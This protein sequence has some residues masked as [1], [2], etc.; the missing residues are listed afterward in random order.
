MISRVTQQTTLLTAQRNLQANA[1]QLAKLQD[2]AST[3]K[4]FSRASEDPS[5]AADALRI[6]AQQRANDQHSRNVNN[7]L[8]WVTT[9]D[10]TLTEVND[11]MKR[12]RD[13]TVQ[14]ANDGSLSATA[15]EAIAVEL[16]SLKD[17]LLGL[18]NT[19]YLGRTVFAGNSSD[20]VAFNPD[21]SFTG[22]P[23]SEVNRRVGPDTT[24]R[25]DGDGSAVFGEGAT[26]VFALIEGIAADLRGGTN[27]GARLGDIDQRMSAVRTEHSAVGSRHA[28]IMR[29]EEAVMDKTVSFEAQ[30]AAVEDI[31]L[32]RII[33]D[34]KAQE[35]T[36]QAA[37]G[38]TAR[39]LQPTLMDFLR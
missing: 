4:A 25:V 3:R 33:L 20:G 21:Y 5:G 12:V 17:H 18:A 30:R 16:D 38:V 15:K 7:G 35:I 22:A 8:G 1:A 39:V 32:S 37:L 26:S 23:G 31:E 10:S 29:A 19:Q 9:L 6:R 36:Y 13:L 28:L 34:L 27:I 11:V 24:V 2:Q 14:G